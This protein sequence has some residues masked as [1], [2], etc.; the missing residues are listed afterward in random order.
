MILDKSRRRKMQTA[1]VA[2]QAASS[3]PR[4][5]LTSA[6]TVALLREFGRRSAQDHRGNPEVARPKLRTINALA[7]EL[8]AKRWAGGGGGGLNIALPPA[9]PNFLRTGQ[10]GLPK[11]KCG[12]R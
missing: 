10:V 8:L 12:V 4:G 6:Q 3:D 5:R 7:R 11:S 1:A 9:P 2:L